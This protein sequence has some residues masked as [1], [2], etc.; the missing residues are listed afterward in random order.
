MTTT[1]TSEREVR[2]SLSR[3]DAIDSLMREARDAI[4]ARHL[5]LA[6][7]IVSDARLLVLATRE[8]A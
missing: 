5:A 6:L 8:G 1:T 3:L 7:D 2:T 4:E